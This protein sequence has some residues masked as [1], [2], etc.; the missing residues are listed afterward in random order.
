MGI[1]KDFET[2]KR[3]TVESFGYVAADIS[4]INMSLVN[5]RT[6]LASAQERIS[7][8]NSKMQAL[9]EALGKCADGINIQK[10]N[11]SAVA[12]TIDGINNTI[13]KINERLKSHERNL[14][15]RSKSQSAKIRKMGSELRES[16]DGIRKVKD[17]IS[18]KMT[19]IK[20]ADE[21]LEAKIRSQRRRI[22]QLNR[23]I[24]LNSGRK[25]SVRITPRK[26]ARAARKVVTRKVTPRKTVTTIKTPK[27]TI[28]KTVTAKKTVTEKITPK[29]R[30]VYEVIREKNP[31][32]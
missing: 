7:D 22:A 28:K 8:F 3:K 20:R 9:N 32:I 25:A 10:S 23:K 24:E 29:T 15:S 26:T 19:S 14:S 4:N 17:S 5:M 18:R 6:M 27:R 31:L 11:E 30:E 21:E 1:R 13:S 2:H 16:R 12:S